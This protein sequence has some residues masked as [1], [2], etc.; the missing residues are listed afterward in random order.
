MQRATEKKYEETF[1]SLNSRKK[2]LNTGKKQLKFMQNF[3]I[4]I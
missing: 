2:E 1:I 3:Q 4:S